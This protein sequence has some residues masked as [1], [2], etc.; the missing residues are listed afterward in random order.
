MIISQVVK[1]AFFSRFGGKL[2]PL[3]EQAFA[4]LE[5]ER[6]GLVTAPTGMGKTEAVFVPVAQRLLLRP[7]EQ[8]NQLGALIISPTRAL[9]TDLHKRMSPIFEQLGLRL[10]VATGDKN[11]QSK[12]RP[13]DALIR[14]PEGLDSTLVRRPSD[15][16][17]VQDIIID[18]IHT[19]L[20]NPR[21]T[22]L[23]GLLHRISMLN[24]QHR[25][26]GISATLPQPDIVTKTGL[27]RKNSVLVSIEE[28]SQIE[29]LTHHWAGEEIIG[30]TGF[31][32]FLKDTGIKKAL[33][34]VLSRKRAEQ[35]T[36]WLNQGH[37]RDC[38]F[39]HH[40]STSS[41]HRKQTEE[42]LRTR[43]IV[44]VVATKTLE[45]GIDIG[46]VDTCILFDT[47]LDASSLVQR[48]GRAGRRGGIRR[49][50]LVS[51]LFDSISE[52][53]PLLQQVKNKQIH[54]DYDPR[55]SL[56]G[57]LQQVASYLM[58]ISSS[59]KNGLLGF[60]MQAYQIPES[61]AEDVIRLALISN[62]LLMN[63]FEDFLPSPVTEKMFETR[64]LHR[65]FAATSGTTV[66]DER[67]QQVIGWADTR[68]GNT[69]LLAGKGREPVAWS[70]DQRKV[71]V[72]IVESGEAA[73]VKAG[74]SNFEFATLANEILSQECFQA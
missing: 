16:Q 73:F 7:R 68:A 42:H 61:A 35:V 39:V 63:Q 32:Q 13:S 69:M 30:A 31:L 23:V 6:D 4:L 29:F 36:L 56:T 58:Q 26:L 8:Q 50:V 51:G 57:C 54:T 19:F 33:G 11:T 22:Q 17:N 2:R 27:L 67:T 74:K 66:I 1:R 60:L 12:I 64:A 65:T 10:D 70:N 24:S 44:L 21:G 15:L 28:Q 52:F 49:V 71:F 18:E 47:P 9:A 37:L 48:A 45:V 41:T 43:R 25:R 40:G 5:L 46:D 14:T 55:P 62:F 34:F 53:M 59:T 72:K 38:V 3:Q 20:N